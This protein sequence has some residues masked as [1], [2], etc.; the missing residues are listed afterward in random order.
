MVF[1]VIFY[2]LINGNLKREIVFVRKLAI[3][4]YSNFTSLF[5][6]ALESNSDDAFF[7]VISLGK[8]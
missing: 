2:L 6:K 4:T 5:F 1:M 3:Y 8:H 7:R